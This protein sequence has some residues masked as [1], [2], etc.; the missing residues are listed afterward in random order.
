MKPVL[1]T[2]FFILLNSCISTQQQKRDLSSMYVT[3]KFTFPSVDGE[4]QLSGYYSLPQNVE[5]KIP[6]VILVPGTG[7]FD[8][9]VNFGKS[10]TEK[11]FIFLD[12]EKNLI[13]SGFAVIRFNYRGVY[14]NIKNQP[15]CKDCQSDQDKIKH[16]LNSC[17][18]F[19]IREKVTTQNIQ[20]DIE[21]I[22]LWGLKQSQIDP[23]KVIMFGH[24]EGSIHISKLVKTRTIYPKGIIFMGGVTESAESIVKWQITDRLIDGIMSFD[25]DRNKKVTTAEIKAALPK[26]YLSV[27]PVEQFLPPKGYWTRAL[28]KGLVDRQYEELKKMTLAIED[29]KPYGSGGAIQASYQWW[30]M[31]FSDEDTVVDNLQDFKGAVI[32][33]N[34]DFDSQTNAN[35]QIKFFNNVKSENWKFLVHERRGHTLGADPLF[36]P[37]SEDSMILLMQSFAELR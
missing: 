34:G 19:K 20:K 23:E 3:T 31:W 17:F 22:Y 12:L 8:S 30:K 10:K 35:R 16:F 15:E 6:L 5:I 7:L 11:D 9:Q 37:I 14:C 2:V 24:S 25:K 36:G 29:T 32:Y 1:L 13:R 33:H 28:L 26:S 21:Q 4:A 27:F 18:D